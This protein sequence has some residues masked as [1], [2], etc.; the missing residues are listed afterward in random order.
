MA[1]SSTARHREDAAA[2]WRYGLRLCQIDEIAT[3]FGLAM[4][5]A[6]AIARPRSAVAISHGSRLSQPGRDC[7]ALR[8]RNDG[9]RRHRNDG[10][11]AVAMTRGLRRRD[12]DGAT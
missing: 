4:T 8:A 10:A 1:I 5:G 6:G 2:P 11:G 7:H 3:P 12:D 9:G